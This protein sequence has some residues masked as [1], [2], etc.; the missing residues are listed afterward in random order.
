[1]PCAIKPGY[2]T[3]SRQ[4]VIVAQVLS[5]STYILTSLASILLCCLRL[6]EESIP[7]K[8]ERMP[9]AAR[10]DMPACFSLLNTQD[11]TSVYKS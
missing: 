11:W 1:M 2:C 7:G 3:T 5:C 4:A 6:C 8:S 9:S 10:G